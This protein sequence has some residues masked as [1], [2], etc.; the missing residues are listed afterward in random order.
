MYFKEVTDTLASGGNLRTFPE[1]GFADK[2][3]DFSSND[4]LGF[5]KLTF[6]DVATDHPELMDARMSSCASRLLASTQKEYS[7]LE[8]LLES[9]YGFNRRALIFNSGY[10]ANTGMINALAAIPDSV[11]FADKL[12]HASIIDG[13]NGVKNRFRFAHND[14]GHLERLINNY[15]EKFRHKIIVVESVYSMDGDTPDLET[16]IEIKKKYPGVILYVDEA[17][18]FGV[19]GPSGLGLTMGTSAPDEFDIVVG[20][21]GKA[22][23]SYGAFAVMK[24]ELRDFFIN[25]ARSLIFSTSLPPQTTLWSRLMIE[26]MVKAEDS[27][28]HLRE[29]SGLLHESLCRIDPGTTRV[30][31]HIA[32]VVTGNP[33]RAVELSRKLKDDG[34]TV[35]PIR[36]PTVPPGTDRL[37]ISLSAAHSAEDVKTLISAL[38]R[39]L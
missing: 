4:Y 18:A 9:L 13:M 33:H 22:L 25:K 5:G 19:S 20:T 37:R 3:I 1:D 28:R 34:I 11:I 8:Q 2:G 6:R 38:E 24:P 10:H 23:G 31:G 36:T 21:F 27:R 30:P 7:N 39:W 12:V 35:L 29:L 32:Y 17:H 14:L 26:R 16:L 15:G